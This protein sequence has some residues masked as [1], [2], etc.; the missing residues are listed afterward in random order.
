LTSVAGQRLAVKSW[1]VLWE[2]MA[3]QRED[4]LLDARLDESA[5]EVL[6]DLAVSDMEGLEDDCSAPRIQLSLPIRTG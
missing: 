5:H 4:D 3:S 6:T 2:Q 1:L